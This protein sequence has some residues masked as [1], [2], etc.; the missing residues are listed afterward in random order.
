[1]TEHSPQL[2]EGI[3]GM[4]QNY[5]FRPLLCLA[6]DLSQAPAKTFEPRT[7]EQNSQVSLHDQGSLQGGIQEPKETYQEDNTTV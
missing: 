3:G 5:S 1:M 2:R 4:M 7:T 6:S